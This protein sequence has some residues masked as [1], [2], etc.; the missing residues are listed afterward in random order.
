MDKIPKP[1]TT[2]ARGSR[3][4]LRTRLLPVLLLAFGFSVLSL[5]LNARHLIGASP[6]AVPRDADRI[7]NQCRQLAL[8]AGPPDNFH[9][10]TVSDRFE[11]GTPPT[12][13]T[14]ATIWTGRVSGHE[15]I[16]GSILID[17]G[18]I[19][20]IGDIESAYLNEFSG[21][22]TVDAGGA[23]VTPGIVDLHSHIGVWS[24]PELSGA[25]DSNSLKGLVLPWLRS[26][27]GLNTHDDSYQLSIAG[28]LTTVNVLPGSAD[29]IGGQAFT[30]KLR[31]TSE[32]STS[33]MLLEPPYTING[34]HVDPSLPP[35]WRQMKHACGENPSRT[36]SGTR[37]DTIW[38]F[39]Q[40]YGTARK[41]KEEQDAY[42]EKAFA[43]E[44]N[45]LGSFPENLQWEALVDVLRGRVKVHNHC[46]EAVDLDGMVRITNEFK[47]PIAAFHHA[48]ETY[49]VP[50][51]LKKAYG[52]PPGV[53]LFA[54]NARYKREAYR[55]SEF[56]PRILADNGIQV[57]MKSD[58]FVLNS[59]HLI[60]E[61][62]QAHFYGLSS[63]LALASVTSTPAAIMGMDHRIGSIRKGYD[64]DIVI[65]D[66]H[67]L[68]LGAAPQQ[69]YIDGISQLKNPHVTT[70]PTHAQKV[71]Q[72]P[73]FDREAGLAVEYDG[74]PPLEPHSSLDDPVLF[75]NVY[76]LKETGSMGVALVKGG[77]VVCFGSY[78]VCGK[79]AKASRGI[80]TIDLHGGT[81]APALTSFGSPLGL[82]DIQL[83][84]STKDGQIFDP[85]ESNV[86]EI[87][88][89]DGSVI[90]AVDGLQFSSRDALLAYR[91]GVTAGVSFPT[92]SGFFSGLGTA[93]M[94]GAFHKLSTGAVLQ[95]V[96]ALHISIGAFTRPSVSTQIALLRRLLD[97]GG[98]GDL[99]LAFKKI[100]EGEI[101]LVI[102]VDSADIMATLIQLKREAE[103]K[104]QAHLKFTF[105]GAAES[106]LLAKEIG[107]AGIG[108]VL[109]PVRPFPYTW[110]SR[111]ILPG[112][113][114]TKENAVTTLMRHNVTVGIGIEES[115]SA[116]NI[117]FDAG[118]VALEAGEDHVSYEQALALASSN[119]EKLLGLTKENSDL[120]AVA[121]GD[122]LS[123]E[124]KPIAIIS[125]ARNTVDLL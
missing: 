9:R 72:T 125:E 1:N 101:P 58:H 67:P 52:H 64:A 98:K 66:S 59:R 119:L 55:G 36:Y 30:I 11:P 28:G 16:K 34:T 51:L 70:K 109:R 76:S 97:G 96:T 6:H 104:A 113:P 79:E 80:K 32:R 85:L 121:H 3:G 114:M 74:L 27:D 75:I 37:M 77:R 41:I 43:G 108:V 78:S 20:A 47:F 86:P 107:N 73:N 124:G 92:S 61:A 14:N 95:D 71:P 46:Y 35:R 84:S 2:V 23:W 99:G 56:A 123:F 13:I 103:S 115:W 19:Q 49:L 89:G 62:Q 112:P 122:F 54:T 69:V 63:N 88:G 17:K 22:V 110:K 120:V 42:C 7:L 18:I 68:A 57:V 8:P 102:A 33:A 116:R 31:P 50:D 100:S 45:D 5:G 53:A 48:H 91:S 106:H 118:W 29:A 25:D 24:A 12:L 90:R 111:R 60:N 40:G 105:T 65:W 117:R 26:L 94:T 38:A 21:L 81:I 4:G 39:R 44:W 83:E 15:V 82:E 10:R 93:F 87:V